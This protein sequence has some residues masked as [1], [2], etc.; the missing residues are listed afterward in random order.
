MTAHHL[1]TPERLEE[2]AATRSL[3]ELYALMRETRFLGIQELADGRE[4][5]W[6]GTLSD[7]MVIV[8]E[9]QTGPPDAPPLT[10][11]DGQM[12]EAMLASIG[13]T[14]EHVL[15]V[16]LSPWPTPGGRALTADEIAQALPFMRR[17]IRL[18]APRFLV[19][20]GGNVARALTGSEADGFDLRKG[21]LEYDDGEGVLPAKMLYHPGFL[22]KEVLQKRLAWDDLLDIQRVYEG[23]DPFAPTEGAEAALP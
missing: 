17:Q 5:Y 16:P 18:A 23:G 10:G 3:D 21:W 22:M 2:I 11:E 12:Y 15:T 20:L 9:P 19:L 4:V 1:V 7:M 8:E 13:L 14:R 6:H